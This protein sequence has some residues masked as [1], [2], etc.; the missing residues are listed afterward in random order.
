MDFSP[1]HNIDFYYIV[2]N[3]NG[4]LHSFGS[5]QKKLPMFPCIKSYLRISVMISKSNMRYCV[6][7][8]LTFMLL[9]NFLITDFCFR[10]DNKFLEMLSDYR[11]F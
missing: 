3:N 7:K 1:V 8:T 6:T 10:G 9:S 11:R 4:Q 2:F 5:D